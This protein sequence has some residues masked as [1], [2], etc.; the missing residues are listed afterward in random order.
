MRTDRHHKAGRIILRALAQGRKGNDVLMAADVGSRQKL[1]E[2]GIGKVHT[3][4]PPEIW[5]NNP[6]DPEPTSRPDIL[7][8][9][10]PEG[11]NAGQ[12]H[13]VELKYGRDTSMEHVQ[14]LANSQ[15]DALFNELHSRRRDCHVAK[16]VVTL[17]VGG[18][19]YTSTMATLQELG[20]RE[21]LLRTTCKQLHLH[22]IHSLKAIIEYRTVCIRKRRKR[23]PAGV[24]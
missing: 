19:I 13:I 15:H 17:G 18:T 14:D 8:Y 7:M 20:V 12:I 22:A 3:R 6:P 24:T 5:M 1:E 10:P 11:G 21:G 23:T 16:R 9:R 4:V 2:A